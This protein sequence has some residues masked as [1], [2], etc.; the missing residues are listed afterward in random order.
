[1]AKTYYKYKER[2]GIVDYAAISKDFSTGI[3]GI[4]GDIEQGADELTEDIL[5]AQEGVKADVEKEIRAKEAEK[6]RARA[7]AAARAAKVADASK[8][9]FNPEMSKEKEAND[10]FIQA[11]I[12]AR[13]KALDFKRQRDSQ[14]ISEKADYEYAQKMS[15]LK[16]TFTTMKQASVAVNDMANRTYSG[17]EDG[18]VDPVQQLALKEV[19]SYNFTDPNIRFEIGEDGYGV[20]YRVDKEGN[21]VENTRRP[22]D[23]IKNLAIQDFKSYDVN[24]ETGELVDMIGKT[25][26]IYRGQGMTNEDLLKK[27]GIMPS[28]YGGSDITPMYLIDEYAEG[29][30][31]NQLASIMTTVFGSKYKPTFNPE[32]YV[33]VDDEGNFYVDEMKILYTDSDPALGLNNRVAQLTESQKSKAIE[34]VKSLILTQFNVRPT[35]TTGSD[36]TEADKKRQSAADAALEETTRLWNLFTGDEAKKAE[37]MDVYRPS[38]EALLGKGNYGG[39]DITDNEI[40]LYQR[41]KDGLEPRV[42]D[43]PSDFKS[44][45]DL[46]STNFGLSKNLDEMYDKSTAGIEG[47]NPAA[48]Y[49]TANVQKRPSIM[50]KPTKTIDEAASDL[51]DAL[52]EITSG[53][54][55]YGK[56][57]IT[58]GKIGL[59]AARAAK[60]YLTSVG[61]SA[62][63][64]KGEGNSVK[65]TLDGI[66]PRGGITVKL[67]ETKSGARTDLKTALKAIHDAAGMGQLVTGY[68]TAEETPDEVKGKKPTP[69]S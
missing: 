12:Q 13:N 37:V 57:E 14:P 65:I 58:A 20:V 55:Y 34:Y 56:D 17:L 51:D 8:T 7:E 1:M 11:A 19:L 18:T 2:G 50:Y 63:V 26:E 6:A 36:Q 25:I 44:F 15:A 45:V 41:T 42:I 24:K 32:E 46:A 4:I 54:G 29:L 27:Q 43:I 5:K 9:D 39:Y 47:F 33:K 21:V 68:P 49:V 30:D 40:I 38:I 59:D 10:K 16:E 66:T 35:P 53:Y 23:F 62:I 22:V 69:I 52:G 61:L 31:D 67:T 48:K 64:E 3:S 60:S 28:I